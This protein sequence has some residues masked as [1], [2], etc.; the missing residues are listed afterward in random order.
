MKK[1]LALPRTPQ[2]HAGGRQEG[3]RRGHSPRHHSPEEAGGSLH[4]LQPH[5]GHGAL[6]EEGGLGQRSQGVQGFLQQL[7]AEVR[8]LAWTHTHASAEAAHA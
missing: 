5:G 2:D 3:V 7:A 1:G 8:V 4:H 6:V